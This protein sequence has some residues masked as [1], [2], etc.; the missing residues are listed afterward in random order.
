VFATPGGIGGVSDL[1]N[2]L[3]AAIEHWRMQDGMDRI[4]LFHN[5][6]MGGVAYQPQQTQL[7]PVDLD[8]LRA[9]EQLSWPARGLPTFTMDRAALFAALVRQHLFVSLYRA[10]VES[11][12]AENISRVT[13]MQSAE[14]NI[15]ERLDDLTLRYHRQRQALI[16]AELLDVVAGYEVVTSSDI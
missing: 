13:S 9:L 14:H 15:Q 12:A 10:C 1:V 4:I 11:L 8:W 5:R 16:T 6:P 3:A 2:E 7:W